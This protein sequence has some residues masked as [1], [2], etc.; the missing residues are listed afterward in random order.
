MSATLG[1]IAFEKNSA[2]FLDGSSSRRSISTEVAVEIDR[3][4]K[5]TI[6]Q[7][8]EQALKI[9]QLNRDLLESTTLMLLEA[10][11]LEGEAL[12]AILAQVQVP[13]GL[14]SWLAKG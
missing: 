9:L 6:D 11:V 2:Q 14:H 4:V 13:T 10:E 5:Q 7:A 3:Q 8:H 1:P 12:Q